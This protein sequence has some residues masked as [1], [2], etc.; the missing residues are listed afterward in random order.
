MDLIHSTN[1]EH[2]LLKSMGEERSTLGKSHQRL[3]GKGLGFVAKVQEMSF[4][5]KKSIYSSIYIKML[6][7]YS[8]Q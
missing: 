8:Q 7:I 2:R 1:P 6:Y 4:S 5:E 3:R